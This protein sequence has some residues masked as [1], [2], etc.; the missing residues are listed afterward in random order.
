V[1]AF[2]I[3]LAKAANLHLI[4]AIAGSGLDFAS[5][6]I[7]SGAGDVVLDY[8]NE[9]EQLQRDIANALTASRALD[10]VVSEHSSWDVCL[11]FLVADTLVATVLPLTETVHLPGGTTQA[12]LV[13]VGDVHDVFSEK[14]SGREFGYIMMCAFVR[15]LREGWLSGDLHEGV[16]GRLDGVQ[17]GLAEQRPSQ[18]Q[19]T[20]VPD[21]RDN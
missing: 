17:N 3:K 20:H 13:M 7:D 14:P 1:G 19:K 9:P 10:A 2:A 11:A 15:G 6:L 18:R 5:S 16:P 12:Q 8:R 21:R 4:I